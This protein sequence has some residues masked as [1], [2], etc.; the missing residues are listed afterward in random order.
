MTSFEASSDDLLLLTFAYES[1]SFACRVP[2][3]D[4]SNAPNERMS[5]QASA[6]GL[7]KSG[8]PKV[9]CPKATIFLHGA[10]LHEL[11]AAVCHAANGWA[12]SAAAE[13]RSDRLFFATIR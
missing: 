3:V 2:S 7:S 9:V 8:T 10:L 6:Q 12:G 1:L 4:R 5:P 13:G 11:A